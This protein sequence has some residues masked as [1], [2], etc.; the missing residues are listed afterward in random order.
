MKIFISSEAILLFAISMFDLVVT[1]AV[2]QHGLAIE[3]NPLWQFYIE[4]GL[5]Y[6]IAVKA[7]FSVATVGALELLSHIKPQT[8]LLGMRV[9]CIIY[10][11]TMIAAN[12]PLLDLL[13]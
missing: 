5:G 13:R 2:V 4:M 3:Y 10:G 6:F 1:T 11:T 12:L 7:L 9:A 8:A